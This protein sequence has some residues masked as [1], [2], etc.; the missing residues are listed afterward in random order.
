M[1]HI[2]SDRCDAI[3]GHRWMDRCLWVFVKDRR[4]GENVAEEEGGGGG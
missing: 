4:E 3:S 2:V 1:V